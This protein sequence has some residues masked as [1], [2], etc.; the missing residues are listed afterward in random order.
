GPYDFHLK[1]KTGDHESLLAALKDQL[2]MEL[3]RQSDHAEYLV[4][5]RVERPVGSVAPAP[6]ESRA[7]VAA[8]PDSSHKFTPTELRRDLRVVRE[9]LEEGHPG[10]YRFTP[11]PALDRVFDGVA[12]RLSRPLTALEFY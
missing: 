8:A 9:A 10:I 12:A 3:V 2:G 5:D 4:V 7:P 1:W 11:K 6:V